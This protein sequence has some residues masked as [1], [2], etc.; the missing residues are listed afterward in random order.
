MRALVYEGP[1][2]LA[3]EERAL[4]EPKEGEV[5]VRVKYVGV[6]GSDIHG[7]LGTTGRRIAPLILG[8]ELSGTVSKL[9]ERVG[10]FSVGEPVTVMP[11]LPCHQCQECAEGFYNLC[12]N[13]NFLGVLRQDGAIVDEI[14]VPAWNV[15]RLPEGM[16][17]QLA[18]LAEPMAVSYRAVSQA[19]PLEGK[20]VLI[21]GCGTI[22]ML[23]MKAAK[24]FRPAS[25]TMTDLSP[26]RLAAAKEMGADNVINSAED[27]SGELERLGLAGRI[28]AVIECVG[29]ADTIRQSLELVK[30]HG[31]VVLVGL[32]TQK[33][34]LNV[35]K[36]VACEINVKG[37]YTYTYDDFRTCVR[38]VADHPEEFLP[39]VNEIVPLNGE[40]VKLF[41]RL[42][43]GAGK[44]IKAMIDVEQQD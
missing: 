26:E 1:R 11:I 22:G 29:V 4:P 32:N 41:E 3:I 27:V 18:A 8:H 2:T 40:A 43:S 31:T 10:E 7:Y 39:I 28:D 23:A 16:P 9:G 30:N 24:L 42:A 12:P 6:C 14:C 35:E 15:C 20:N 37:T 44:T 17:L 33:A 5:R 13:R 25:V 19:M 36:I 21:C 38:L 34:E